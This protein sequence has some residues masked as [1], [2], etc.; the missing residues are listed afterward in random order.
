M[1]VVAYN[2][3][4]AHSE[5]V[6]SD[7]ITIDNSVPAVGEVVVTGARTRPRIIQTED[8]GVWYLHDDRR[9]QRVDEPSEVCR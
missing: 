9:V 7:G 8:K 4:L 3:A 1:T 6:C 5:A 2:R